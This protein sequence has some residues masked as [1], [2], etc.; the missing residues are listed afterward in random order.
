MNRTELLKAALLF[1]SIEIIS[2]EKNRFVIGRG[3]EIE[4]EQNGLYKL[5]SDGQVVAPFDDVDEL[6]RFVLL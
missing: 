3:Y 1:Y 6:C 2:I 5:Y 4:A